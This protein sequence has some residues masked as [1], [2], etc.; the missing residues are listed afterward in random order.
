MVD[1][2]LFHFK[3]KKKKKGHLTCK[4]IETGIIEGAV[5]SVFLSTFC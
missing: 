5:A 3:K 2:F 1:F 4:F